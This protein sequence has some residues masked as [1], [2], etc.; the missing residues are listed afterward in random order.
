MR[1][2]KVEI[3]DRRERLFKVAAHGSSKN[4]TRHPRV[5]S[6]SRHSYSIPEL[7]EEDV[8][9]KARGDAQDSSR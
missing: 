3:R 8:L 2:E 6:T 5:V 1:S 9:E 4:E 7:G